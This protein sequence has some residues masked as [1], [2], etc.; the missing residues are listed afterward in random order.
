MPNSQPLIS[1]AMIAEDD[2]D[3]FE[4]FSNAVSA[5]SICRFLVRSWTCG[6]TEDTKSPCF[7]PAG[8]KLLGPPHTLLSYDWDAVIDGLILVSASADNGSNGF[9]PDRPAKVRNVTS[10]VVR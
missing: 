5:V 1:H 2:D 8:T 3:D 4:V 7:F 9:R 6:E 10:Q